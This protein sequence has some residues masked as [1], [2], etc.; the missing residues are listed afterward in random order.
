MK[1]MDES[2]GEGKAKVAPL[3]VR[4]LEV[5]AIGWGKAHRLSAPGKGLLRYGDG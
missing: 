5:T 1:A 3:K 2:D 4:N